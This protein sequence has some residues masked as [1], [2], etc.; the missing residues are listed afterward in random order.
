M[1]LADL[2]EPATVRQQLEV[3]DAEEVI[4]LLGNQ[5]QQ[6]GYVADGF[7]QATLDREREHP[8]G[9]P[10]QGDINA[11]LPHV[12]PEYVKKPGLAIAT[13]AEPVQFGHMVERD[14]SI[15]VQLVIMLALDEADAQVQTLKQVASLL[16]KPGLVE[17]LL[18][19]RTPAQVLEIVRRVHSAD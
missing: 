10:L 4:R 17:E 11:A 3:E 16:Q 19:S 1:S 13:L 6:L 15:P 5:L 8:T 18:A 2:L 12:E 14:R 7:V 9:L